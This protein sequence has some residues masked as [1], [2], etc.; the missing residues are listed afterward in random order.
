LKLFVREVHAMKIVSARQMQEL[1]RA[2]INDIGIPGSVLME[3][4]GRGMFETIRAQVGDISGKRIAILCGRGNNGGDGFVIARYFHNAGARVDAFLFAESNTVTGDAKINLEA[5]RRIGGRVVEIT[6][7]AAWRKAASDVKHAGLVVDALLGTGLS[8]EVGGLYRSVIDDVNKLSRPTVAAVDIPSGIDGTTGAVLGTA[9]KAHL[10]CTFGYPKRG[11]VLHPGAEYA[12]RLE[13]IDIGIPPCLVPAGGL[14]E[15]LLDAAMLAGSI[16]ARR[17]DTH[18]GSYGHA[19]ILAGSPGKTGAAAMTAQAA[20]RAGAGL[21]TLGVPASLNPILEAKTSEAMTEPL[22]EEAGGF[23]GALALP[24]I[25]EL[26]Q[27]KSAVA[28]GP[29]LGDHKQAAVL[30]NWLVEASPAPLVIDADGLNL[31][32]RTMGALGRLKVPAV[33]TPHPGEMAR[34]AART[35][36]QIQPDR[37]GSARDFARQNNVIVVLKGSRTVIAAPDGSIC[38]NPTGNPGMA[39]G[40]MGDALTG[41]ITGLIAQGLEPLKASLLAVY[42]HGMIGDSIARER[43]ALGILASDIIE[44]IPAALGKFVG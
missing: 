17:A 43:G 1:D 41:L 5:F 24:R 31:L 44:R 28:I 11:L 3:N 20:M 42:V 9:V 8:A 12:G 39:S 22:P 40:G 23:L 38:V 26:L 2:T 10:T 13:I 21:V 30:M 32:A 19:L 36:Q 37:I 18:K 14:T 16:P 27:G 34:L 33:L 7:E 6:D 25:T 29:G 4:A 15:S 35:I